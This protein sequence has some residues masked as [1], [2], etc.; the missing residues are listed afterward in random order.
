MARLDKAGF[1]GTVLTLK[2]RFADFTQITRSLS[3]I[4][5]Q[6]D[7]ATLLRYTHDLIDKADIEGRPHT[8]DGPHREQSHKDENRAANTRQ[9]L[10]DFDDI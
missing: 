9:L 5:R 3:G 10:I 4:P 8:P 2:V 7:T 6:H 1:N